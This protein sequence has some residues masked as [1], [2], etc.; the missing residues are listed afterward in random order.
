MLSD[1]ARQQIKVN[2]TSTLR[3]CEALFPLL[4]ASARVVNI[5]SSLGKLKLFV[6]THMVSR[7]LADDLTVSEIDSF[8]DQYIE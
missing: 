4:R 5:A 8:I 6:N 1:E 3:L 7:L 2:Y